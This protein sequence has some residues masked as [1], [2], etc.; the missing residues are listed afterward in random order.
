MKLRKLVTKNWVH[1]SPVLDS[2]S[3]GGWGSLKF[4]ILFGRLLLRDSDAGK[5][6]DH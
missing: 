1:I 4:H 3:G 2:E 6:G 5:W